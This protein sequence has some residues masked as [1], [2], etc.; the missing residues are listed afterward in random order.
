MV[1]GSI[2]TD[3]I[4]TSRMFL[5]VLAPLCNSKNKRNKLKHIKPLTDKDK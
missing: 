3:P 1:W 2:P 4:V 5:V